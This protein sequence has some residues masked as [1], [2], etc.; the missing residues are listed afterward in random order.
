MPSCVPDVCPVATCPFECG[1]FS[2]ACTAHLALGS[3]ILGVERHHE[4]PKAVFYETGASHKDL[5]L[6]EEREA[7]EANKNVITQ[8]HLQQGDNGA[9]RSPLFIS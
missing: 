3:G 4:E 6:T 7:L 9:L 8:D 1:G 5:N 2:W